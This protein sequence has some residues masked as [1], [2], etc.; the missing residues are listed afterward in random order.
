MLSNSNRVVSALGILAALSAGAAADA[1]TVAYWRFEAGPAGADVLHSTPNGVFDGTV[2]D[3]S[4]NG[5][6]LSAWSQ[7][8]FAGYGYRTPVP[9]SVIPQTG[10]QNLFS[11][12][13]T[14]GAPGM[15]TDSS[16]SQPTG[17]DIDAMTPRAFTV[18]VSVKPERGGYRTFVGRDAVGVAGNPNTGALTAIFNSLFLKEGT[19]NG[20]NVTMNNLV[21]GATY[22][23]DVLQSVISFPGREVAIVM[24][25]APLALVDLPQYDGLEFYAY[26]TSFSA[27]ADA[28]GDITFSVE[29]SA[30]YGGS[31]AQNGSVLNGVVLTAVPDGTPIAPSTT[32]VTGGRADQGLSLDAANVVAAVNVGESI[33]DVTVQNVVFGH[34]PSPSFNIFGFG[35]GFESDLFGDTFGDPAF[36]FSDVPNG[37]LSAVYLQLRP[38][39]EVA[40]IFTDVSGVV[41]DAISAPDAIIGFDYPTDPDG[42]LA[43]WHNLVG[44]SDGKTI[45]LYIDGVLVASNPMDNSPDTSLARGTGG[46]GDW[47]A[48]GWSV[49]RG[50]F[51]GRH[52]DRGYGYI[53]EVRISNVALDPSQFLFTKGVPTCAADFNNDTFVNSQDYFDFITAFFASD[54]SADVNHDKFVNSQDFFDFITAFFAGC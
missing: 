26:D 6:H 42:L 45:S 1:Q 29:P 5:N 39:N 9:A 47:H 41:H 13:N 44:V 33:N 40:F 35:P 46:G 20:I 12:K 43:E 2:F 7:G 8:D 27:V 14:G 32:R 49:G 15:F 25:G 34:T 28:N 4:G 16:F 3:V 31:G 52:T 48:G 38:A 21:P 23:L 18:E 54:P 10:A 36:G 37:A 50:F 22:K 51:E 17:V 53:D 24:N 19:A 11:V 30:N